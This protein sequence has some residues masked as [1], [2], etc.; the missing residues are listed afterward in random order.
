MNLYSVIRVW[1]PAA[2]AEVSASVFTYSQGVQ[3]RAAAAFPPGTNAPSRYAL[4]EERLPDVP[5]AGISPPWWL[6]FCP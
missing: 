1:A 6:S 3:E 2:E 4:A 5:I